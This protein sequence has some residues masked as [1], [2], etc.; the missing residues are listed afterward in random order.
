[1]KRVGDRRY[2]P[3]AQ[4]LSRM[5]EVLVPIPSQN[6]NEKGTENEQRGLVACS[7]NPS[8]W[9]RKKERHKFKTSPYNS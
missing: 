9:E 2:S 5:H 7:C 6:S 1:M 4:C 8:T 3:G